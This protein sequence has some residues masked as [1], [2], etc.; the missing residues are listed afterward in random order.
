MYQAPLGDVPK[1][2][3]LPKL[4]VL[5]TLLKGKEA[6]PQKEAIVAQLPPGPPW[7]NDK[8]ENIRLINKYIFLIGVC[9]PR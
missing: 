8:I 1:Q 4:G 6:S 3:M 7:E 9:L 5:V 2:P